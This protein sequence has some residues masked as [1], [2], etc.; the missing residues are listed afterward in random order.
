MSDWFAAMSQKPSLEAGVDLE[1]PGPSVWWPTSLV[2]S[3]KSGQTEQKL[4]DERVLEV[5]KLI[6]RTSEVHSDVRE[7]SGKDDVANALAHQVA[8]ESMVL[9]KNDNAVLPS[10]F[11]TAP[12]VALV[13]RLAVE[14][15]GGG[16]SA[17]GVP[18]YIKTPDACI[19]D[20]HPLSDLVTVSAGVSIHRTIPMV[21]PKQTSAR[22]GKPSVDL[23]YFNNG[24]DQAV[25]FES[26]PAAMVF[27]LGHVKPGLTETGF[28]YKMTTSLTRESTGDHTLAV[29]AT[30]SFQLLVDGK[31]V[32][33]HPAN[34]YYSTD[35]RR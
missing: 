16:G 11:S 28:S 19:K 33:S 9:L 4:I 2:D 18:H 21:P 10:D 14:Y 12:K 7:E 24:S 32:P 20:A 35:I 26:Q 13:G 22:N 34:R 8:A 5:L 25:L 3:I 23:T 31:E 17:G 15:S 30:G 6:S 27:M 1:M 29:T